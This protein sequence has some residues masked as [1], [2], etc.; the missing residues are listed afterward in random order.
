[1]DPEPATASGSPTE[2]FY[3]RIGLLSSFENAWVDYFREA[4][5]SVLIRHSVSAL[6]IS[7]FLRPGRH[8]RAERLFPSVAKKI[9]EVM[10]SG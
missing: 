5:I 4:D 9:P 8:R 7:R 1:M 2:R 6:A 10:L 3:E